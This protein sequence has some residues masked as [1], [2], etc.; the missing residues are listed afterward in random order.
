[1]SE[2]ERV[3]ELKPDVK[4]KTITS[5]IQNVDSSQHHNSFTD[6]I[7]FLQGTAGNQCVQR[8][9]RSGI[10]QAQIIQR[11][12]REED[13]TE[14][15]TEREIESDRRRRR[16]EGGTERR[17]RAGGDFESDWAGRAILARYLTGGGD[18]IIN[19]DPNWSRYMKANSSI[20]YELRN[21]VINL[22]QNAYSGSYSTAEVVF[23][24]VS[25]QFPVEIQNGEGIVGYQYL[26]GTDATV[27]GFQI[28][29]STMRTSNTDGVTIG[30]DLSYTWNDKIDPNPRY[31]TDRIKNFFAELITLGRANEYIIRITWNSHSEIKFDS[32]G[33][34]VSKTGWPFT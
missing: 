7:K 32:S 2:N 33:R 22:A 25:E 4:K 30:L 13:R 18:W 9:I 26:H 31:W 19:N 24:N 14:R 20:K 8:M 28:S 11:D 3:L 29:G 1:M 23:G 17:R 34:I 6:R 12:E 5:R 15:R 10:I 21:R 27:G 16:E